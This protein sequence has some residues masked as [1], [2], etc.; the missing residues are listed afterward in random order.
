MKICDE[1]ATQAGNIQP[2]AGT[3]VDNWQHDEHGDYRIAYG[4]S[5]GIAGR[6]DISV[7]ATC[8]QMI[9]GNI[10]NGDAVE[11]PKVHVDGV[12]GDPL[13]VQQARALA[14]TIMAT[15]DELAALRPDPADP[16]DGVSMAELLDG[17]ARRVV[18]PG[19]LRVA[20]ASADPAALTTED[21]LALLDLVERAFV[22]ECQ[23][24]SVE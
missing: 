6:P 13:T 15:A 9:D 19:A 18:G 1:T 11:Q 20:I 22:A 3:E 16:L 24:L 23:P 21:R 2:P 5:R 7:Q 8:I 17:I 4:A 14:A 10:D 12:S